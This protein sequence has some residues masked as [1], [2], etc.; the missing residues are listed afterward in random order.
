MKKI[1]FLLI[2]VTLLVTLFGCTDK[3]IEKSSNWKK[4]DIQEFKSIFHDFVKKYNITS[5]LNMGAFHDITPQNIFKETGCQI[6]KNGKTC[7]SYLLYEGNLY[8]LGMGFGG[9][10]IIKKP[11]TRLFFTVEIKV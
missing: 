7:E 8:T 4:Q 6:F 1:I 2:I 9:L 11:I 10:G 5:S 3:K